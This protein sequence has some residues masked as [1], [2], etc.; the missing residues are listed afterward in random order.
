MIFRYVAS[1]WAPAEVARLEEDRQAAVAELANLGVPPTDIRLSAVQKAWSMGMQG[2]SFVATEVIYS[3]IEDLCC[4]VVGGAIP[5]EE[6]VIAESAY[7]YY[8]H[9]TSW[10]DPSTTMKFSVVNNVVFGKGFN[11]AGPFS[12]L[13]H[14]S[15]EEGGGAYALSIKN[16]S[17]VFPITLSKKGCGFYG[18]K[19]DQCASYRDR[20]PTFSDIDFQPISRR[21]YDAFANHEPR[22][23]GCAALRISHEIFVQV[24]EYPF[25]T[26]NYCQV[27]PHGNCG[28]FVQ[29]DGP[30]LLRI[31]KS[32]GLVQPPT[33]VMGGMGKGI[34]MGHQQR[35]VPSLNASVTLFSETSRSYDCKV[36]T[37]EV[38]VSRLFEPAASGVDI[39][40]PRHIAK[41]EEH[42]A[43]LR[44]KTAATTLARKVLE[45]I[46]ASLPSVGMASLA[47][48]R[49]RGA[50]PCP[51]QLNRFPVL[52][53][54]WYG[55][56]AA[57]IATLEAPL[58]SSLHAWIDQEGLRVVGT[59]LEDMRF[60]SRWPALTE[61]SD[62]F[63][64]ISFDT[65]A[66]ELE[67]FIKRPGLL[68]GLLELVPSSPSSSA[69][70]REALL[71]A[72]DELT[73]ATRSDLLA[74]IHACETTCK[75][76]VEEFNVAPP[77]SFRIGD[78]DA[79]PSGP[80]SVAAAPVMPAFG[81]AAPFGGGA[82]VGINSA[83]GASP[84]SFGAAP[85]GGSG[86]AASA[87]G[88]S[89]FTFGTAAGSG[90]A[91]TPASSTFSFGGAPPPPAAAAA[92]PAAG[93]SFAF[94]GSGAS[95]GAFGAAAPLPAAAA[96]S[97]GAGG[98]NVGGT[99]KRKVVKAKRPSKKK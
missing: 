60:G 4:F 53:D 17:G 27:D 33:P 73:S 12:V 30:G 48:A 68:E 32:Q 93:S 47:S 21:D 28:I 82:S 3:A 91:A 20:V 45:T 7:N 10:N 97:G 79:K 90:A 67:D 99:Y 8:V 38:P 16:K 19:A 85:S 13:G 63:A 62:A 2:S 98:F 15:G 66:L 43:R 88:A 51:F 92:A 86:S 94:G 61:I 71:F 37:F 31:E 35:Q 70:E 42:A 89:P 23:T 50:E 78:A 58:V 46:S 65:V 64:E 59:R 5:N 44:L 14:A 57:K 18:S 83:P 80:S 75:R 29:G 40:I 95:G 96:Q 6:K 49:G 22:D 24:S 52:H 26:G 56:T 34:R 87:P 39:S 25:L 72:E 11:K 1:T 74:K 76:L 36:E 55:A 54:A 9:G 77:I 69:A 41:A 81:G 84:F